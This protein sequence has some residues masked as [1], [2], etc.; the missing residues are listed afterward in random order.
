VILSQELSTIEKHL[1]IKYLLGLRLHDTLIRKYENMADIQ[2][3]P[4]LP[5]QSSYRFDAGKQSG[6]KKTSA[7]SSDT[8]EASPQAP[9]P[10]Q[11]EAED[12]RS[13][14]DGSQLEEDVEGIEG[15]VKEE[16]ISDKETPATVIVLR[17]RC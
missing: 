6:E 13:H 10:S 14:L 16:G 5:R 1:S 4:N 11:V 2:K 3:P 8:P 15:E 7:L 17:S 12:A 9:V